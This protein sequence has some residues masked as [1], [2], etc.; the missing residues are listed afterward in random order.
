FVEV[1]KMRMMTQIRLVGPPNINRILTIKAELCY[2]NQSVNGD[3]TAD[4]I[5]KDC[6]III[7]NQYYQ[8]S[9]EPPLIS[10]RLP[11][12]G[13]G[14]TT[15][16]YLEK[17]HKKHGHIFTI[18]TAGMR[19]IHIMD[20]ATFPTIYRSPKHDINFDPFLRMVY[21][22]GFQLPIDN[23]TKEFLD[24]MHKLYPAYLLNGAEGRKITADFYV[25]FT[26]SLKEM[27][28]DQTGIWKKGTVFS[29]FEELFFIAGASAFYGPQVDAK[30]IF[31][32]LK[33]FDENVMLMIG[34]LPDFMIANAR[35]AQKRIVSQLGKT[36]DAN[37]KVCEFVK[38][39]T[40]LMDSYGFSNEN[41]MRMDFTFLWGA[42]VNVMRTGL[43][44]LINI[45][46][47]ENILQEVLKE[48]ESLKP[49]EVHSGM[50][51]VIDACASETLR[52]D[53][54]GAS[55]RKVLNNQEI[56]IKSTNE[57]FKLR[58]G[59]AIMCVF[60]S[61]HRNP[62]MYQGDV[63]KFDHTRFITTDSEGVTRSVTGGKIPNSF[64]PFG[65]GSSIC[66]GR[67]IARHE[68]SIFVVE[69]LR[70]FEIKCGKGEYPN[71]EM[72]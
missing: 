14:K 39:R 2:K 46:S 66:Q 40:E 65:G 53:S 35:D 15:E 45:I 32:D 38:K 27:F 70:N 68:I 62:K 20:P 8:A 67:V 50:T 51:P 37:S 13:V 43:L 71:Q 60:N 11:Y 57:T 48:I 30:K 22:N 25:Y 6:T 3:I 29:H 21:T 34:G 69:I 49:G 42:T 24:D 4:I 18:Y 17:M 28:K 47:R 12:I 64:V 10:G 19:M 26:R 56:T 63:N 36:Q 1:K 33:I 23:L 41:K 9:G 55:I 58:E 52:L 59:D 44:T 54:T 31:K 5:D 61:A 72:M 16:E 7:Y